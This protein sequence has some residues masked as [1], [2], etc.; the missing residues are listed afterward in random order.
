[1]KTE[2]V[3]RKGVVD[4]LWSPDLVRRD[5]RG[6]LIFRK[7]HGNRNSPFG[8]EIDHITPYSVDGSD[9]LSNLRPV[10]WRLN[11][12]RQPGSWLDRWE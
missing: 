3:W 12:A 1:M 2:L 5:Y 7:D 10:Q 8:W 6:N 9:L 11:A 4:P